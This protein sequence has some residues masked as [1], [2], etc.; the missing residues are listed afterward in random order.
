MSETVK[1]GDS[2]L[3]WYGWSAAWTSF[4]VVDLSEQTEIWC[5]DCCASSL[6]SVDSFDKM[7]FC[8]FPH[9][10]QNKFYLSCPYGHY[11]TSSPLSFFSLLSIWLS[12]IFLISLISPCL[13][14]V[15][16][17][18]VL[19]GVWW[20]VW[21]ECGMNQIWSGWFEWSTWDRGC[22]N[23]GASSF[24]DV[25]SFDKT[26][27]CFSPHSPQNW[28][29]PFYLTPLIISQLPLWCLSSPSS[30]SEYAPS[31]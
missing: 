3:S 14:P 23:C 25:D 24:V 5:V 1:K 12:P 11:L 27:F 18:V 8:Y 28:F 17:L 31:S 16:W 29:Y 21:V 9:S 15:V 26:R 30:Q 2:K 19:L 13:A 10:P 4:E 6:M 22:I 7:R 20:L